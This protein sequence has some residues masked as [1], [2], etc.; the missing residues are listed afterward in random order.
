MKSRGCQRSALAKFFLANSAK[1]LKIQDVF[2][3]T[4]LAGREESLNP[5]PVDVCQPLGVKRQLNRQNCGVSVFLKSILS[6]CSDSRD[7]VTDGDELRFAPHQASDFSEPRLLRTECMPIIAA[8]MELWMS[9]ATL[10][11]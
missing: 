11:T 9:V 7:Q 3:I 10:N 6:L 4:P 5:A 2:S 8:L 1:L